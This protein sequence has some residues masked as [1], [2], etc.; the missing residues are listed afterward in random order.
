MK[1]SQIKIISFDLFDTLVFYKKAWWL[2]FMLRAGLFSSV[3]RDLFKK[4]VLSSVTTNML[5]DDI[6]FRENNFSPE[7]SSLFE[8]YLQ[9]EISSI[10]L[11]SDVDHILPLLQSN[12]Y[13]IA[14]TSNL[15]KDFG[16]PALD[17][18]PIKPDFI[19]FSYEVG[20]RKPESGIFQ[21]LVLKSGV[22]PDNILHIGDKYKNDYV[23]AT[24]FG[25]RAH[26]LSRNTKVSYPSGISVIHSLSSLRSMVI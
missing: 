15:A 8:K 11:F 26:L 17:L 3:K 16:Q 23:G 13:K 20:Y 2:M 10:T 9:D 25:I 12:G 14:I 5:L 18:L 7:I 4:G 1:T 21:Q 6:I 19:I 22:E 24:N